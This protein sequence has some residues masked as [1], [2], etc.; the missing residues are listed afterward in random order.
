MNLRILSLIILTQG[1]LCT[2]K[3]QPECMAK[4]PDS[5]CYIVTKLKDS[6]I[7]LNL[8]SCHI[9][10]YFYGVDGTVASFVV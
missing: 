10:S 6:L 4:D 2:T 8:I 5:H 9:A 7:S 3:L 1:R